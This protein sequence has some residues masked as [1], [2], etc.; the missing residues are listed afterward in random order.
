MKELISACDDLIH[1]LK[2]K[3]P[4]LEGIFERSDCM[5]AVYPG[6][7]YKKKL[8]STQGTVYNWA[9]SF[10]SKVLDLQNILTTLL[11]TVVDSLCLFTWTQSGMSL[12]EALFESPH[13]SLLLLLFP[14]MRRWWM[15]T[16]LPDESF[17]F[18]LRR[19]LMKFSLWLE[20]KD[21]PLLSGSPL[22]SLLSIPPLLLLILDDV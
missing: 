21:T 18:I 4:D 11:K 2:P 22:L 16:P 1:S 6:T 13:Q 8:Y 9:F 10:L 15:C 19:F 7:G 3:V 14:L 17:F 12:M 20:M 5:L